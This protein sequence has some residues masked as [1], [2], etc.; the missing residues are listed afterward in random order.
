MSLSG[1]EDDPENQSDFERWDIPEDIVKKDHES[2]LGRLNMSNL[3][4]NNDPFWFKMGPNIAGEQ[5]VLVDT[6]N[7]PF[8]FLDKYIQIDMKFPTQKIYGFG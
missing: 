6:E 2:L 8:V 1:A 5:Q 4:F 7:Q 3:V